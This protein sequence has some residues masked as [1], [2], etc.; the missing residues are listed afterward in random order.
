MTSHDPGLI[1]ALAE[2]Y[3]DFLAGTR[4]E[5][6]SLAGL[7][8]GTRREVEASWS[9]LRAVTQETAAYIPPPLSE[10]P[11]ARA[12]G[13]IPDPKQRLDGRKLAAARK[14]R[15]LKASQLADLLASRGWDIPAKNIVRW[16]L[17]ASAEIQPA[18]LS[19]ISD[20]LRVTP[21]QLTAATPAGAPEAAEIEAAIST[22]RFASLAARWAERT[23][24]SAMAARTSLRQT[25]QVA[26]ARRGRQLTADE[27]L[28]VLEDFVEAGGQEGTP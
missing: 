14:G 19:A 18:V 17:A 2:Q 23:G 22:P 9:L 5:Q 12:L 11:L 13:L 15:G 25:M 1:G 24:L 4:S 27:W 3:L 8:A 28:T 16:E 21:G 6:P 10:D 7:D 26:T 20:I